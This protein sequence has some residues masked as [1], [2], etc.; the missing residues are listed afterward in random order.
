MSG[1]LVL[2]TRAG[3]HLCDEMLAGAEPVA[4]RHG[5]EIGIVDIDGDLAMAS[6]YNLAI[7]VLEL[8]GREICRHFLDRDALERALAA[9]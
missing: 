9:D 7:P 1:R 4:S 5:L 8:D 2:Y 6:R 3:C